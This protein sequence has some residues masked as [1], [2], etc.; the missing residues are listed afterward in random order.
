MKR[1]LVLTDDPL[2]CSAF[3]LVTDQLLK[4]LE[5][6]EKYIITPFEAESLRQSV[7]TGRYM[8]LTFD[9]RDPAALNNMLDLIK[10]EIVLVYHSWNM[11]EYYLR[12]SQNYLGD[13]IF[14][15]T[16]EV[17]PIPKRILMILKKAA[18]SRLL[19]P[20]HYWAN[21]LKQYNID[22]DVLP[23]GVDTNIFRPL[24]K[25]Q[26]FSY[27][28][29]AINNIR[30]LLPRLI[31]AFGKTQGDYKLRLHTQVMGKSTWGHNLIPIV[32]SYGL[33]H[34]IV[35]P[36]IRCRNITEMPMVY[37]SSHVYIN[38]SGAESFCL[39][40]LESLACG[41]GIISVDVPVVR[42]VLG[43]AF[44]PVKVKDYFYT[45]VGHIPLFDIDEMTNAIETLYNNHDAITEL[46]SEG[47]YVLEKYTWENAVLK[48]EE[49]LS[50]FK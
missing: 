46:V 11:V 23:H 38:P 20:T 33:S 7:N 12:H 37:N 32:E 21:K 45:D 9:G 43:D 31:Y 25:P 3:G 8:S 19:V 34:R 17:E 41:L 30:K 47:Q 1:L 49:V 50:E 6:Y 28:T 29:V 26:E 40:L 22:A 2:G 36:K 48:L 4:R 10:P 42:E 39:P 35:F 5:G 27:V 18:M 24:Q 14:Y 16:V 44:Y 15:V 13:E